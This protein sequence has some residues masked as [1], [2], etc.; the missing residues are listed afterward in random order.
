MTFQ[1]VLVGLKKF[2]NSY[3]LSII[4]FILSLNKNYFFKKVDY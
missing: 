1:I 4:S 2:K 3:K